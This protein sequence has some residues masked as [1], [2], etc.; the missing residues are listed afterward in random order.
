[1]LTRANLQALRRAEPDAPNKLRLAI[2]LDGT[3]QMQV[4]EALDIP[5]SQVSRDAAG[6]FS[7]ISL[8]K[9]R[10]YANFFGCGVEDLFPA[11]EA[12]AS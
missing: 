12:V 6:K 10:A 1:M 5:Q 11:R 2:E 9:A 8:D 3:T 4:A 7:A